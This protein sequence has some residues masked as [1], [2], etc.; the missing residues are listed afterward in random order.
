[1][2]PLV[3]TIMITYGH[4]KYIIDAINGVIKQDYEGKIELIIANDKSP[5][6]TKQIVD[7]YIKHETIPSNITINFICHQKNKGVMA[8]FTWAL[9]QAKGKYIALCEGDDYWIDNSK[10][11]KQV[12]FL[13]KNEDYSI[14]S[15]HAREL[16]NKIPAS[17]IGN[18]YKKQTYNITDF[19]TKNNLITCTIM[20]KNCRI[21]DDCFKKIY[22]GDWMLYINVLYSI[23]N[24]KAYVSNECYSMYRIH[25]LGAMSRLTNIQLDEK[26]IL[27]ITRIKKF[28]KPKYSNQDISL[29]NNYCLNIY[30]YSIT[31]K[32]LLNAIK[33]FIKNFKLVGFKVP[34]TIYLYYLRQN[35]Y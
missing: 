9:K 21:E 23:P 15:S 25:E 34:F 32:K 29:I 33:I 4:E 26:H 22:F 35:K 11:K 7:D 30:R 17:I 12:S 20:F 1:M 8:N 18:Y 19:F 31:H 14:H 24:S 13:E 2:Y 3:S 27:Q 5:D 6:N 28:F 10:L 16:K